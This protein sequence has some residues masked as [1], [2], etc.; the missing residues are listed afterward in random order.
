M[1]IFSQFNKRQVQELLPQAVC[2]Q[3][4]TPGQPG[5]S[6]VIYPSPACKRAKTFALAGSWMT[7]GQAWERAAAT[8]AQGG[9]Q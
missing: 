5:V 7:P 6:Y 9:S 1:S 2:G 3:K 8:I 4:R